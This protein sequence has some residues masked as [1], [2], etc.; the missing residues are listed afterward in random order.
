MPVRW[1]GVHERLQHL[2][3]ADNPQA[4]NQELRAMYNVTTMEFQDELDRPGSSV[5]S[6][7][8]GTFT[9]GGVKHGYALVPLETAGEYANVK[10]QR[11]SMETKGGPPPPPQP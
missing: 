5:R 9:A 3:R 7:P 1:Q 11:L 2:A 8:R 10:R 4:R 6:S